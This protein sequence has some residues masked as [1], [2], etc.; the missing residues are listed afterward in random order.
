VGQ[1]LVGEAV[2]R[3]P[4]RLGFGLGLLLRLLLKRLEFA[5]KAKGATRSS[6]SSRVSWSSVIVLGPL[7]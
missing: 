2:L 1:H 5:L 7:V 4:M 6:S 3:I